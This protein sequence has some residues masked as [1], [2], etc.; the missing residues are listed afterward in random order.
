MIN[1]Q[2][3]AEAQHHCYKKEHMSSLPNM[4]EYS[5]AVTKKI[6]QQSNFHCCFF[7]EYEFK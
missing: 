3:I 1:V 4:F 2:R 5:F 7:S 6:Q